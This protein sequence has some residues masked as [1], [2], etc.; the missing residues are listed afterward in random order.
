M[1]GAASGMGRACVDRLRGIADAVVTADI[2]GAVDA[3]C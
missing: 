3:V 1:T 2:G